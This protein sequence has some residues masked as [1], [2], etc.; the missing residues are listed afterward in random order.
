MMATVMNIFEISVDTESLDSGMSGIT[1]DMLGAY[2]PVVVAQTKVRV[3]VL[4][5]DYST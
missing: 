3:Y 1:Y 4:H 2:V 5:Q